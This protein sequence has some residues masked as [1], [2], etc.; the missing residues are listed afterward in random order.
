MIFSRQRF[1]QKMNKRIILYY[2]ETSG[3]LVF[4]RFLEEI[5]DTEKT[6][7]NQLTFND[8]SIQE[9]PQDM[10]NYNPY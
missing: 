7:R 8:I 2:D 6:F 1:F 5:E 4:V 3:Q 9:F 10:P